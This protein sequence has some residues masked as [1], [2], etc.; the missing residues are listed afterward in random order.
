MFS[1]FY[2]VRELSSHWDF[3]RKRETLPYVRAFE[4]LVSESIL[5]WMKAGGTP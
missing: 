5:M 4:Q 3:P 1:E 2:D